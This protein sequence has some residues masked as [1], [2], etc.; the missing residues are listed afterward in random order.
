MFTDTDSLYYYIKTAEV[1]KKLFEHRELLDYSDYPAAHKY[2]DDSNKL[3]IGIFKCE[4][5]G[6]SIIELCCLK[7]KVYSLTLKESTDAQSE[8]KEKQRL[9]GVSRAAAREL[10]HIDYIKQLNEPTENYQTNRRIGHKAHHLFS[11][12]VWFN[13]YLTYLHCSSSA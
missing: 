3:K 9:K 13:T 10:R 4:S 12:S 2:H 6:A 1:E 11:I 5:K 8:V 7:P